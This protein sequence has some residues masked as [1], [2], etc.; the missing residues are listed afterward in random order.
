MKSNSY[1]PEK[2]DKIIGNPKTCKRWLVWFRKSRKKDSNDFVECCGSNSWY[3]V[4]GTIS[5]S[6]I[7]SNIKESNA[8]KYRPKNATAYRIWKGSILDGKFVTELKIVE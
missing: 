5:L 2:K 7:D 3:P 8:Y 6:V 4:N 1:T